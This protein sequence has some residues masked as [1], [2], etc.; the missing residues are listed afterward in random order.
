MK[1]QFRKQIWINSYLKPF[2][3]AS[4]GKENYLDFVMCFM[5]IFHNIYALSQNI[6]SNKEIKRIVQ[7]S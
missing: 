2:Y 6:E 7:K 4:R 5:F 3:R 1:A